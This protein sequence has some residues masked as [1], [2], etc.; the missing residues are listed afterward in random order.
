MAGTAVTVATTQ[1]ELEAVRRRSFG[2]AY[3]MLGSVAEA[4]DVAQESM[5]RLA[6]TEE[7]IKE[8]LAWD[9]DRRH[10]PVDQRPEAGPD[11]PRELCR[12][13]ASRAA[14]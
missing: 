6:R 4:E 7:D 13:L 14:R 10:S 5:L 12:P 11:T 2:I 1:R 3:R 9:H 8:P